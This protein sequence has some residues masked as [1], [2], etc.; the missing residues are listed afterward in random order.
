MKKV[1]INNAPENTIE[2]DSL[3]DR[4]AI[5]AYTE[6]S[7]I[8]GMVIKREDGRY[9]L[10]NSASTS[11]HDYSYTTLKKCIIKGMSCGLTFYAKE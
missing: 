6:G 4:H 10:R 2:I 11:L 9:I 5:F 8:V 7:M 1:I 3:G